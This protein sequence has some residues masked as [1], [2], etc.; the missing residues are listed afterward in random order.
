M[1]N[2]EG[3]VALVTGASRGIGLAIAR[4]L[5]SRGARVVLAA[6]NG[7][8][9]EAAAKTLGEASDAIGVVVDVGSP[10][11]ITAMMRQVDEHY[12]R[13]D[14]VVNNAGTW[15]NR[16]MLE[17]PLEDWERVIRT[18]LTGT[19]LVGQAAARRMIASGDGGAIVNISSIA[20]QRAGAYRAAYGSSKAGL[21][22]LTRQMALELA[23]H[24]IRVNAVAPGPIERSP[25][26]I[27][28]NE[29]EHTAYIDRLPMQ[30]F[31]SN[32]EVADTVLFLASSE[33]SY[34]TGHVL[35]VDGGMTAAG[36]MLM[37]DEQTLLI[38]RTIQQTTKKLTKPPTP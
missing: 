32:E 2:L 30:R 14:I 8:A 33:S 12:G 27:A 1:T 22:Q 13:L 21:D 7:P 20:G 17:L 28:L 23:P 26:V 36:L 5:L 38:A 24:N 37:P 9:A 18:N 4:T 31:G 19:F 15:A 29:A 25:G 34:M 16:P 10:D 11:L 35:N 3:K 6:R